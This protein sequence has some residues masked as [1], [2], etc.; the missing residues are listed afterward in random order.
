MKERPILFQGAMVRALLAGT[1]TQTRR[2]LKPQPEL[3]IIGDRAADALRKLQDAG[4]AP[5]GE[6]PRW[7]WDGCFYPRWP[8]SLHDLS[9]YGVPGDRLWVRET[10]KIRDY[11]CDEEPQ[12][13]GH[14]CRDHCK[15]TYVY[16]RATPR[17]GYRPKPDG[18]RITYLD[19][20][21]LLT[22][23]Y[24]RDWRPSIYLPRWASRITLEVTEVRVQRLQEI[25]EED[26]RAEG[27]DWSMH[28]RSGRDNFRDL[29]DA[30]NGKRAPW[31][32]NPWLWVISFKRLTP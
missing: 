27:V 24:E 12:E 26:A 32:S 6:Q 5:K 2:L 13:D 21:T 23:W 15:Q 31:S 28:G 20:S 7:R 3:A 1:K 22:E 19:E 18:A 14:E 16:Y 17:V 9:P 11:S 4:I 25:S 8:N 29:W 10:F 30:I